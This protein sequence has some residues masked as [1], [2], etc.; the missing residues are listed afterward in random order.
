MSGAGSVLSPESGTS[1]EELQG[2]LRI[3]MLSLKGGNA[4]AEGMTDG[5][6]RQA[7][8]TLAAAL[9][10]LAHAKAAYER[11]MAAAGAALTLCIACRLACAPWMHPSGVPASRLSLRSG[12]DGRVSHL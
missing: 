6:A 9:D 12:V 10:V 11:A 1:I 4:R 2:A 3:P 5:V 7:S 8:Q